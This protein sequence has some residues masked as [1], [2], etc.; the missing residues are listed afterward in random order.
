MSLVQAGPRANTPP[1]KPSIQFDVAALL[2]SGPLLGSIL[3]VI[4]GLTLAINYLMSSAFQ[5]PPVDSAATMRMDDRNMGWSNNTPIQ[6]RPRL[7]HYVE[8]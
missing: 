8:R 6:D 3:V 2:E 4:T 1:Q 5:A 7:K